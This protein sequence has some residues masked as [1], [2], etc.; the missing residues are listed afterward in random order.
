MPDGRPLA[1]IASPGALDRV[2]DDAVIVPLHPSVRVG[3]GRVLTRRPEDLLHSDDLAVIEARTE[4]I[5]NGVQS[6]LQSDR[7]RWRGVGL[8]DC[9][10]GDLELGLRDAVKTERTIDLAMQRVRAADLLTDVPPLAGAFPAYPYFSAAGTLLHDRAERD[11]IP[12][13][14]LAPASKRPRKAAASL[15]ARAYLSVAAT[16]ALRRLEEGHAIVALGPYPGYY[17]PLAR[18]AAGRPLVVATPAHLP[19]RADARSGLSVL[20][21]ESFLRGEDREEISKFVAAAPW[22]SDAA[23]SSQAADETENLVVRHLQARFEDELPILATM[24][25]AFERGLARARS[26]VALETESPLARGFV[27]YARSAAI[28]VTVLQHGIL[29]GAFS[30]A[31][32]DADRVAAWGPS[33]AMWFRARLPHTQRVEPTGCPRYDGLLRPHAE[34]GSPGRHLVVY[35]S[36]PFVQDRAGRSAWDRDEALGMALDAAQQL[37]DVSLLV[38]WHPAESSEKLPAHARTYAREA[39]GGDTMD[40]IRRSRAVL[41]TSSTVAFEA[42]LLGRP[43]VFLGPADASSP[44]HPPE[45]G[46]GLRA[47]DSATLVMH[48]RKVVPDGPAREEVLRGQGDFLARSYAPLDGS[49]A[50]RVLNLATGA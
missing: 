35:A 5:L 46:G 41:A 47:L 2:P 48:L 37:K 1:F 4:R 43:V 3:A 45:D 23:P 39:H 22:R 18:A 32:T 31:R 9:F 7:L 34:A 36:Q 10:L 29:A 12:L 6:R 11:G 17:T 8:G 49:A 27:R 20:V 50:K 40:L 21:L 15:V 24:G 38:K 30:Y 16:R 44:F 14:S 33:D 19:L 28:P 26:A 42:M 25:L 13:R